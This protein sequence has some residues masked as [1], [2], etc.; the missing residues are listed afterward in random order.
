MPGLVLIGPMVWVV[1]ELYTKVFITFIFFNM[2]DIK[3]VMFFFYPKFT[4]F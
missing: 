4:H 3:V 2:S 1:G